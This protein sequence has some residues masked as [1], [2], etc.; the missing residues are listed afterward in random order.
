[1]RLEINGYSYN[2]KN[3]IEDSG[4]G[5]MPLSRPRNTLSHKEGRLLACEAIVMNE[6]TYDRLQAF[7]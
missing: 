5:Q 6:D 4:C 1:M 3:G 2:E 7:L